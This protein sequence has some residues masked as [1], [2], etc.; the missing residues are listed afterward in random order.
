VPSNCIARYLKTNL[1]LPESASL[2]E[3]IAN[4]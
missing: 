2:F 4:T 3:S 1:Y